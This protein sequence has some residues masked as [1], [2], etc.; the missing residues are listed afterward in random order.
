MKKQLKNLKCFVG[1]MFELEESDQNAL[2]KK[3]LI[4]RQILSDLCWM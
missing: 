4:S 1:K 3:L 2:I